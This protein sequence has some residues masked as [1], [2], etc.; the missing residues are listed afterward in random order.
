M[1]AKMHNAAVTK[2]T[3]LQKHVLRFAQFITCLFRSVG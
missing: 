2:P 3:T 1:V